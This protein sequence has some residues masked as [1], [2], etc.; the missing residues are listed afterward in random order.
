ME[1]HFTKMHGCGND[2]IYVD[3]FREKIDDIPKTAKMLSRRHFSVGADGMILVCPSGIADA[4]MRMFN[5]DGSEG[6]MCGNGIRCVAKFVY[7]NG[8]CRRNPLKIETLSGIKTV[9]L[10]ISDGVAVAAE[11]DMGKPMVRPSEIPV[12]SEINTPIINKSVEVG[13]KRLHVTCVSMGN[14][15][16]VIFVKKDFPL[17]TFPIEKVGPTIEKDK[18]FP[19]GVNVEFVKVIS[20]KELEMR[21]WERGS[22][23]TFACGTGA[24]A[25]A[26]AAVMNGISKNDTDICVHLRGGDLIINCGDEGIK[27][28][29]EAVTAFKGVV[30]I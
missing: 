10:E 21:V 19:E 12:L 2:Y 9:S 16:C 20:G 3:A 6:K 30:E 27:M 7:D 4:K 29:G 24:C 18:M 25:S 28:R 13:G 1:L 23:E 17:M 22:G 8:L 26:A 14:P 11:V 5:A 15:H